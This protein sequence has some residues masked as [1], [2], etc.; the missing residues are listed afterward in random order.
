MIADETVL[1]VQMMGVCNPRTNSASDAASHCELRKKH[2]LS[3]V[4]QGQAESRQKE[5]R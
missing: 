1:V 4:D 2:G 5:G 3:T